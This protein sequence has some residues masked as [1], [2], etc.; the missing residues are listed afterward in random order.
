MVAFY[1]IIKKQ[2]W[3]IINGLL[4]L[5]VKLSRKKQSNETRLSYKNTYGKR[6]WFKCTI[7]MYYFKRI[8][9][10]SCSIYPHFFHYM[11][12]SKNHLQSLLSST[13]PCLS[14]SA[15][16][17]MFNKTK[18][19]GHTCLKNLQHSPEWENHREEEQICFNIFAAFS[20]IIRTKKGRTSDW[21]NWF[22]Y[23]KWQKHKIRTHCRL[24][25]LTPF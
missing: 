17:K 2:V 20:R 24:Q 19:K 4:F 12:C 9:I 10:I 6:I 21:K 15:I 14:S 8:G 23:I 11:N 5:T 16:Q 1:W 18:Q 3:I 7:S 25:K 22:H 13:L